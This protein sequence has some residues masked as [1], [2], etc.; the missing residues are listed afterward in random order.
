MDNRTFSDDYLAGLFDGEGH[1]GVF[2][3]STGTFEA[4]ASVTI[5]GLDGALY[6]LKDRFG[7]CVIDRKVNRNNGWPMKAWQLRGRLK[8]IPFLEFV[9][10]NC[11][12]K[13]RHAGLLLPVLRC[14][15]GLVR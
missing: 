12:L 15:C 3:G 11:R 14:F 4:T 2:F 5:G 9:E 8:L 6:A 13:D 7:G 1:I 10:E